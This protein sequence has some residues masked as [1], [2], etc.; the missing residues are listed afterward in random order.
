MTSEHVLRVPRSDSP[1][2]F[3]LLNTGSNGPSPL[4]LKLLA[5]EGTEPYI[6]TLKQTRI[7]K[8][9]SS[10]NQLDLS[11]WETI[12]RS[13]FLQE[14]TPPSPTLENI[15]LVASL[16][17][18]TLVLTF[19]KSISDIHQALGT[20]TFSKDPALELDIYAW[21]STSLSQASTLRTS[22]SSLT[23]KCS[24][25]E[26]AIA[27]LQNQLDELVAAKAAHEDTLLE[28][29]AHLLN[30]K[31]LKIRDQQRII[32]TAKPDPKRVAEMQRLR[33]GMSRRKPTDSRRGKRKAG[34]EH[35]DEN[36]ESDGFEDMEVGEQEEAKS[37][38]SDQADDS[39]QV[40][41]EHSDLDATDDDEA[42]D[43]NLGSV[44]VASAADKGKAF[45]AP[46]KDMS[47][48]TPS[49][50]LPPRRELL[51][52]NSGIGGEKVES[53][54]K[55]KKEPK[56]HDNMEGVKGNDDDDDDGEETD[57]DEL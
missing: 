7:S 44:P 15:S 30:E 54:E 34:G 13:H 33:S 22:L 35:E 41:P 12:L 11:Q 9:R 8:Y 45:E 26:H 18:K 31:K 55:E 37:E 51:V 28:K 10:S 17:E 48:N 6:K 19:R 16:T 46:R 56:G 40:T 3:I 43:D 52:P 42:D 36:K 57:D 25:Q 4:D 47:S 38:E 23:Q 53:K 21:C 1:G 5:T 24:T 32:A 20:F 2:D 29:F 50:R 49:P 14:E 27:S 39:E